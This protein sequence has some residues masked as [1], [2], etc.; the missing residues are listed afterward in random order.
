MAT[1][2]SS[3]TSGIGSRGGVREGA[4][5]RVGAL[6]RPDAPDASRSQAPR[7]TKAQVGARRYTH[8]GEIRASGRE[9]DDAGRC[10]SGPVQLWAG[11]TDGGEILASVRAWL[12]AD[13]PV[14][15]NQVLVRC[16]RTK[17][18]GAA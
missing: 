10:L 5:A 7:Y 15:S 16:V 12:S 8:A 17:G 3:S 14:C 11:W 6:P 9:S 1:T 18:A 13:V 2:L 4:L